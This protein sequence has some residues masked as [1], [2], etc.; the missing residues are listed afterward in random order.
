MRAGVRRDW[1]RVGRRGERPLVYVALGSHANAFRT[2]T[3][4]VD[5]KCW[6]KEGVAVYR[7]YG[8]AML[9]HE[10]AGRTVDPSLVRVTALAPAWLRFPGTWG[11]DQYAGF[12]NAVF[13]VGTGPV[14]PAFQDDWRD[15]FHGP[16]H[17]PRG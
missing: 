6:P 15:P 5:P 14:G 3:T 11:E 12:P 9:D 4:R 7:A 10:A 13:K 8:V 17:W 1:S 2:G 16:L